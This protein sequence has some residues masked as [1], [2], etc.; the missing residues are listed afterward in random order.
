MNRLLRL[1]LMGGSWLLSGCGASAH[2][3]QLAKNAE[4]NNAFFAERA[5]ALRGLWNE[6]LARKR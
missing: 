4:L 2:Q 3:R 1:M 6:V 5:D